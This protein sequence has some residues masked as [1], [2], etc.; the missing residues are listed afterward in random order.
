MDKYSYDS[1]VVRELFRKD[2]STYSLDD[3]KF[4]AE[5]HEYHHGQWIDIAMSLLKEDLYK[6]C[7]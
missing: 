4:L 7:V 1:H 3:W 2:E 5:F 6:K